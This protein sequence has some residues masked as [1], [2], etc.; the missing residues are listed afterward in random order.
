MCSSLLP[1]GQALVELCVSCPTDTTYSWSH[2]VLVFS[3]MVGRQAGHLFLPLFR[4]QVFGLEFVEFL[5]TTSS[6]SSSS[7][8]L[9]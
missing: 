5:V 1:G 2:T 4:R 8:R 9:F 3:R 7:T 6:S